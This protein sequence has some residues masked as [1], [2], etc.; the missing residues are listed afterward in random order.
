MDYYLDKNIIIKMGFNNGNWK[1]FFSSFIVFFKQYI[2]KLFLLFFKI[3][4]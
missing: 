2:H 4:F 3:Y 1:N